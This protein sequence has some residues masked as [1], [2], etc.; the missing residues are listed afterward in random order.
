MSQTVTTGC[1]VLYPDFSVAEKVEQDQIDYVQNQS[2]DSD[3]VLVCTKE[4]QEQLGATRFNRKVVFCENVVALQAEVNSRYLD[5]RVFVILPIKYTSSKALLN[6]PNLEAVKKLARFFEK[7][8]ATTVDS[9]HSIRMRPN[10]T[11][12]DVQ[13]NTVREEKA[14]AIG[15]VDGRAG[16]SSS[17]SSPR[18]SPQSSSLGMGS[19]DLGVIP[20]E[21][22]DDEQ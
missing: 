4:A 19:T 2:S 21:N 16:R 9:R 15:R 17:E 22:S 20:E 1:H 8:S 12:D 13:R 10:K 11:G 18:S 14:G 7:I 6:Y 3:T 5:H